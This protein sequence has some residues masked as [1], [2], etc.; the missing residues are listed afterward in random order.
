MKQTVVTLRNAEGHALHCIWEAPANLRR[1][2]ACV[3]LSPG[4]KMRVAPHRLYRKVARV[5][6]ERGIGVLRV[7]FHGL[8]DSEGDLPE[9]QLDQLYRKVQQGRHVCDARAAIDWLEQD[10]GISRVV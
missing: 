6:A 4:V 10:Q 9:A 1:D 5:F 8:G 3:L 2:L 7:D